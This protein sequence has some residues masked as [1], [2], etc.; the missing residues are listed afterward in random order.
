M[1]RALYFLRKL[2]MEHLLLELQKTLKREI[3]ITRHLGVTVES[4]DGQQLVLSAPLAQNINHKGTAFAGSLNALVTLAGWGQLWLILKECQLHGKIVIQD[5]TN[6]YLLPVQSNFRASCNRPSPAQVT[7]MENMFRKHHR[8]RIELQAEIHD[9]S[10]LA[11]SF[12]G[13][14]VVLPLDEHETT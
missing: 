10:E 8:A 2:F 13:R 11:V 3:P 6:S 7:R 4:Y 14:Y 5:S 12:T 1:Q 9:G